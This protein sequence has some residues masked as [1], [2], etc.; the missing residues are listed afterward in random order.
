MKPINPFKLSGAQPLPENAIQAFDHVD[1]SRRDFLKTAG[2]MM[3][4]FGAAS[5]ATAQSPI[6]PSGNVD[7]TQVDNW[8]AIAADESITVFSGKCELGTGIRT[9]QHQLAAEELSV[10]MDRITLVL[11]RT[12]VTPNQGYTAGSFSTWTQFGAGGLR[13]ALDTARDAL[14]QLASQYLDAD[15]SQLTVKDGVF[16]VNG[17]D[18]T[19]TV[20]YGQ[21][22]QGQRFNLPVNLGAVPN[23]PSTWKLLGK[24]VARVD[25]P[26]KA[27]G[28]F[29]YAQK[30]RVPGMLHGKVVRPPALGAHLLNYHT[31]ALAGMPGNPKIVVVNDFAGVVADTEW[32]ATKAAKALAP[33]IM[34]SAG[35]PLPAQADLYTFMVKQPSRDAFAVN[36]GDVD[37]V[38]ATAT[39]TL[40]AQYLYPYQMH[41]SLASSCAVA[42]VRGTGKTATV[43][44]WSHTQSVYDVRTYLSTILNIPAGNIEVI[45]VEGSGCYGGNG[46][47]PV[48]FDAALLSQAVGKPVRLQYSRADEMTGGEH[49]GHPMVSNQ[50][51]GLDA[52]GGIIAWDYES[53]MME[54]GEGPLAGF[55]FGGAA[56]PGNFISGALAGFPT[57]KVVLTTTPINPGGG[58]F[59]NFGNSV[60]PY[61]T[62]SVNGANLGTGKVASQRSLTRIAESPLWTSYLRSPDHIQN[63]WAHESFMDEIAASVKAD[64]VQYRLRHLSD[65]RL[66]GV[67]TAVTQKAGWDTR[68]SPKAGNARTGVVT[69]RGVSCV[70][71][72][73]FDGYCAVVAE[74]SVD[75]D[76]GIIT[77]TKATAGLDTGP[78]INP[79]GLRNQMEGQVIQGISRALVEE[80][81]FDQKS[82]AV[83][84]NDWISYP[85]LKFG[86]ALPEIDTVLI[87]NLKVAPTGAGETIITLVGSAIGNAVFDATGVRMRQVPLTPA[88]FL[89]AKAQ[90]S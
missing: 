25:I 56:G 88:N 11:C 30:V 59:W 78:V 48:A 16:S 23:A 17:G 33:A 31:D 71:Y 3:I 38:M 87:N 47:D 62:G 84:S 44:V 52:N 42:D 74:V 70:L 75:Q 35:D 6:N 67:L 90:K 50:K 77:V 9:L 13:S 10:P 73:G 83:T 27:K 2:V 66:I 4:G 36:T 58:L 57:S 72:S 81:T 21:L 69:G 40:T 46:A 79:N 37:K 41:G 29:Q 55:N 49:Y 34:W 45:Q 89:A 1:A 39:K 8:V 32:N 51:V 63:T 60:P 26:A 86:D 68:P 18:P 20:S 85:V 64:P 65:Q 54:H 43:K 24:S 12:G 22:V 15:V 82:R 76:K 53:V 7:A 14:F 5:K 80:V 28:T 19:Y 61:T